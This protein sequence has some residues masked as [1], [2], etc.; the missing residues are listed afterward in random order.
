MSRPIAP[1]LVSDQTLNET[2]EEPAIDR[3]SIG[4]TA[5]RVLGNRDDH[6]IRVLRLDRRKIGDQRALGELLNRSDGRQQSTNEED[7]SGNQRC[8]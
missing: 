5:Q 6:D 4:K 8:R 3:R 1:H 7:E 2:C